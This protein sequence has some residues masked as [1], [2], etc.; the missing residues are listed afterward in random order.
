M[1]GDALLPGQGADGVDRLDHA[2]FI[3]GVHDGNENRIVAQG[4][5]DGFGR[6]PAV[7]FD[8]DIGHVVP[9]LFQGL[10]GPQDGVVFYSRRDKMAAVGEIGPQEA[11][12][13]QI[14]RFRAAT[15]EDQVFALDA[16]AVGHLAA[17]R[18]DGSPGL[19]AEIMK[20]RRI[21][22]SR[23][24]IRHHDVQDTRVQRRRCRVI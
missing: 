15:G 2:R 7:G 21:S 1:K 3:I 20:A 6:D 23:R 9:L 16:Q 19:L 17:R 24:Q 11:E 22:V 12:D 14:V 18:L 4:L 10:E 13:G 8:R 5:S